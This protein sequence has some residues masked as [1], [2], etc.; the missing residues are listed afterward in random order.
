MNN[1]TN[2]ETIDRKGCSDLDNMQT[3][4]DGMTNASV[5]LFPHC[6]DYPR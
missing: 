4:Y 1:A 6:H 3:I 5:L 2:I